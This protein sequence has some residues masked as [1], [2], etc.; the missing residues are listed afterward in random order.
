MIKF[1]KNNLFFT[2]L[3]VSVVLFNVV[4]FVGLMD[5]SSNQPTT[6]PP[7]TSNPNPDP[8]D[9]TVPSKDSVTIE[10]FLGQFNEE[11]NVRLTWRI[12]ENG[13]EI[14]KVEVFQNNVLLAN[15]TNTTS[16]EL[17][18]Y[19]YGFATGLNEF[20][21]RVTQSDGTQ[22]S[23]KTSVMIEYVFDVQSNYEV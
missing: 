2:V 16:Y 22:I 15:V 9:P 1:I 11:E 20:E 23:K 6:N 14:S 3:V 21:L 12:Q 4:L 19:A 10:N 17:P 8:I 5:V 7:I 13:Y 18:I